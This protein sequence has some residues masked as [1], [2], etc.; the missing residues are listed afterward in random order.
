MP[1]TFLRPIGTREP[2]WLRKEGSRAETVSMIGYTRVSKADGSQ[3]HHLQHDALIAAGVDLKRIYQDSI[4]GA[5]DS[6]PDLDACLAVL[7]PGDKLVIWKLDR[8]RRSLRHL[9]NTL[10]ELTA[11]GIG[12]K[13]LTGEGAM[14]DTT[15]ASG[16]LMFGMFA[17]L[18]GFER[19]LII[20][21]TRAG[22]A[23]AKAR[24]KHCGR[25]SEMAREKIR[26]LQ[27]AMRKR[28]IF[29]LDFA[30][31][32]G[33]SKATAYRYVGPDGALW[34]DAK[35]VLVMRGE[36]QGKAS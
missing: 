34:A 21:R 35:R 29:V 30:A 23:A 5:R 19:E 20:E 1:G 24:G 18:A 13:V 31:D 6:R 28:E 27:E 32:I 4:S 15:A 26:F 36:G 3:V 12:L 14:I 17:A 7:A 2:D 33:I 8:L 11:H 25:P 16:R 10:G 22:I 9:V